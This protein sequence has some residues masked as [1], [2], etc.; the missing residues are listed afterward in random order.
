MTRFNGFCNEG[1]AI[2][3]KKNSGW[4]DRSF[5]MTRDGLLR[6]VREY[7]GEVDPCCTRQ[8]HCPARASD[9]AKLGR[10]QN[11]PSSS[12]RPSKTARFFDIEEL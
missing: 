2:P 8:T 10:S 11:R 9:D 6:C 7:C 12:R 3:C 5:C 1:K 4:Q